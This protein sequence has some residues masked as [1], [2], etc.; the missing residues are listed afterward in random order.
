MPA[1]PA[2][3]KDAAGSFERLAAFCF[4]AMGLDLGHETCSSRLSQFHEHESGDFRNCLF[5]DA[6][7]PYCDMRKAWW[8]GFC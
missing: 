1:A 5:H 4:S 3:E 8:S 7:L 6:L 2:S